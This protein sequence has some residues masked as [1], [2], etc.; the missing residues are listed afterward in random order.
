MGCTVK[1]T[2]ENISATVFKIINRHTDK[3]K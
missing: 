3:Q 2:I 1:V